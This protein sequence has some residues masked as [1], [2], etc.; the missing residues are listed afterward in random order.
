M[1]IIN[2]KNGGILI[3]SWGLGAGRARN[4]RR[5]YLEGTDLSM[6]GELSWADSFLHFTMNISDRPLTF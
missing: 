2:S 3:N 6:R 1:I 5:M 4:S